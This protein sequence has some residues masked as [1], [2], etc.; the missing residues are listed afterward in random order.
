MLQDIASKKAIP[1]LSI[2]EVKIKKSECDYDHI[3][4]NYAIK[5]ETIDKY[6]KM[7]EVWKCKYIENIEN[8]RFISFLQYSKNINDDGDI[9]WEDF[10]NQNLPSTIPSVIKIDE[11][12]YYDKG[13]L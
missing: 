1:Q 7:C 8:K 5:H 11:S 9:T 6:Y 13:F 12:E 10:E 4:F 2:G 3:G